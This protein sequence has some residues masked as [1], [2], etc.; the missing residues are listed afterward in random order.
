MR[1]DTFERSV[2][3]SIADTKENTNSQSSARIDHAMKKLRDFT[4][5]ELS[6]LKG[7]VSDLHKSVKSV[8][9]KLSS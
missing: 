5:N 2:R 6:K 4:E 8:T 9:S 7:G 1:L 3:E